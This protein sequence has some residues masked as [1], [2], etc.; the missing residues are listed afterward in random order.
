MPP[1]DEKKP[2][3]EVGFCRPPKQ[4]QFQKGR[5]G[6]PRG[7]PKHKQ[8][9]TQIIEE[10]LLDPIGATLD[11]SKE[12]V[13]PYKL[14]LLTL[15]NQALKDGDKRAARLLLTCLDKNR[16]AIDAKQA[17]PQLEALFDALKRGPVE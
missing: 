7:R 16:E 12:R 8:T 13:S 5:S 3:G 2:E 15:R 11:G 4:H 10:V 6:N 17:N 1:K 14:I 9:I